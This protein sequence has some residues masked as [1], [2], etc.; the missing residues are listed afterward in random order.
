[1]LPDVEWEFGFVA[2]M[3]F[4][5]GNFTHAV[6]A[7]NRVSVPRKILDV[8]KQR[9]GWA[10]EVVLTGGFDGC[11]YLY[12]PDE[13]TTLGKAVLAGSLG[14][15]VVRDLARSWFSQAEVCPVDKNGR[16]L[17]PDALK[18]SIDADERVLFLG[19][20]TRVELWSPESWAARPP[21]SLAA[22]EER[23]REVWG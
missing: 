12:P 8:L 6:D 2:A 9:E 22:C 18:R 20:G 4:F 19:V 5:T 11:L 13:Y 7:K 14:D 23:A 10:H 3:Q 16:M 17:L 21:V 1:M 15:S